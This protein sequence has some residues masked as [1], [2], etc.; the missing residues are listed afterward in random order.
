MND[1]EQMPEIHPMAGIITRCKSVA[2]E[3]D[4]HVLRDHSFCRTQ[5]SYSALDEHNFKTKGS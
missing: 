3:E 1:D 4:H 2:K 5:R